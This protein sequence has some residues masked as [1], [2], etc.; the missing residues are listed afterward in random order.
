M[1]VSRR[2]FLRSLVGVPFLG[3]ALARPVAASTVGVGDLTKENI[4]EYIVELARYLEAQSVLE[5]P[6]WLAMPQGFYRTYFENWQFCM[7]VTT[8]SPDCEVTMEVVSESEAGK[9]WSRAMLAGPKA[10]VA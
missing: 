2:G 4:I 7:D 5:E 10:E 1:S 9:A 8:V 6:R 3:H